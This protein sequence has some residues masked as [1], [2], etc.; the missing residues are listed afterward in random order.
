MQI[1]WKNCLKIGVSI[2]FLYLCI[3]Y[4][5]AVLD[6]ATMLLSASA[7][8]IIG[9][10]IAYVVNITMTFYERHYFSKSKR[11]I[12]HKTRRPVCILLAFLTLV[13]IVV[14]V[15]SLVVPQ[16]VSCVKLILAKLPDA[17]ERFSSFIERFDIISG[18]IPGIITDIDWESRID[19]VIDIITSGAGSVVDVVIGTLASVFSG[20]ATAIVSIIFSVYLLLSKDKIKHQIIKLLKRYL[21]H[22]IISKIKYVVNVFDRSFHS[23]FVAQCTE[24][25]ILGILCTI[26]MFILSIPYAAMVGALIA[27][28]ALVPIVGAFIGAIVGAFM[29][30]TVSPVKSLVFIVFIIVLQQIE[31]NLIYPKVVGSSVNLPGIWVLAAITVG[32]GVM[33][34]L[35]MLLAVPFAAAFYRILKDDINRI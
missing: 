2:F 5:D 6:L 20:L 29:I 8:L 17:M 22:G 9:C 30:L 12:A 7:P 23:Y 1:T 4:L 28:T 3:H 14:A 26:G 34:I 27:F 32:G 11:K 33:G 24:A 13:L 25:V 16:L 19:S 18:N 35:G 21:S 15:I 31:E 10:A